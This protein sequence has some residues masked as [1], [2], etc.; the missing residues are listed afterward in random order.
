MAI[1][2]RLKTYL[3]TKH[4]IYHATCLQKRIVKK[5]G[6]LISAQNLGN[7]LNG[8][9]KSIRLKTVQLIVTSL[10][11]NLS[12]FFEIKP[13]DTSSVNETKKLSY[14]NTPLSKRAVSQFPDPKNYQ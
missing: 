12:D 2:W 10:E 13:E 14:Q 9:P 4:G 3:A 11:C 7:Y 1:S 6:V 5:T 8:K